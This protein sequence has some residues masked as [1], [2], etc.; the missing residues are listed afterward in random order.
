MPEA[1]DQQALQ[2]LQIAGITPFST[3]DWP[4]KI[5]ATLFLQG[6]PFRCPYCHN[7]GIL[8]P[9]VPGEVTWDQGWTLLSRRRG[10][11][12][13]VVF[14]GGEALMQAGSLRHS[15]TGPAEGP[16][17]PLAAAL[18]RTKRHGFATGLHAAGAYPRRLAELVE[19]DAPDSAS[20]SLP[21]LDWVGLDVK[22]LPDEYAMVTGSPAAVTKVEQSLEI[23]ASQ[24]K[25]DWEARLTLW[26]GL[27]GEGPREPIG[28][29]EAAAGREQLLD[30]GRRVAQ[31]AYDRGAR[32]FALQRYR[33]PA[34][35]SSDASG[36]TGVTTDFGWTDDQARALLDPIGFDV[37]EI[38]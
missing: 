18:R 35:E 6:C 1:A 29:G 32:K 17:S 38:R 5:S 28:Y 7:S 4:G 2:Q 19:A 12:D 34:H 27:L 15:A 9:R 30:Y 21:L 31:W 16:R 33:V 14:S 36:E 22:A 25:V 37:L 10:L 23:L 13:G 8:D 24:S 11:L 26:P 3:V 20:G